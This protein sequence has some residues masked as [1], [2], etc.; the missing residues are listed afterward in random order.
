MR[1][2]DFY[3]LICF[4]RKDTKA[5]RGREF[6]RAFAVKMPRDKSNNDP[7]KAPVRRLFAQGLFSVKYRFPFS[8]CSK[9]P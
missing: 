2:V 5:Q 4:H 3:P 7:C 8:V 1:L 9:L 6:L